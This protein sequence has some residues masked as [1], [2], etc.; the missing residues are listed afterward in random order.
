MRK[1]YTETCAPWLCVKCSIPIMPHLASSTPMG[2][3]TNQLKKFALQIKNELESQGLSKDPIGIDVYDY[4][5][6][7]ALKDVG[8]NVT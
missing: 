5:V 7:N 1:G 6:V 3:R 8:V 2:V 4:G